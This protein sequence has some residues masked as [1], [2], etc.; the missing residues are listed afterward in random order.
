MEAAFLPLNPHIV[1]LFSLL[2]EVRPRRSLLC[3]LNHD[4]GKSVKFSRFIYVRGRAEAIHAI[5]AD[6]KSIL[7]FDGIVAVAFEHGLV[8]LLGEI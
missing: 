6:R 7:S 1:V 8:A 2:P 5:S 4:D 3:L